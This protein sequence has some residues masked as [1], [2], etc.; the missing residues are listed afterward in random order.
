MFGG[1]LLAQPLLA[2]ARTVD[3]DRVTND[4]TRLADP[5]PSCFWFRAAPTPRGDQN[6]Q[7]AI[8]SFAS[9]R[10]PLPVVHHTR[11]ELDGHGHRAVPSVDH[12]MWFHSDVH[13]GERLLYVQDSPY[14][15]AGTALA[16]GLVHRADGVPAA[17][18][19]QQGIIPGNPPRAT[20]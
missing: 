18:V 10:S 2:T 15:T 11:G 19:V 8:L 17:T 4:G 1:H 5:A 7:R 9:D 16:R 12:T 6:T 20:P 3:A 14:S 13:A